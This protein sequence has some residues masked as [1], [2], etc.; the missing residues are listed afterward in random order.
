MSRF[1]NIELARLFDNQINS[2]SSVAYIFSEKAN[3]EVLVLDFKHINFLS[4]AA[5]HELVTW[6]DQC[7]AEGKSVQLKNLS[8]HLEELI[9]SVGNHRQNKSKHATYVERKHFKNN[10]ELE[11][12]LLTI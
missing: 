6:M 9:A 3:K 8:P 1:E 4:R 11:M 5:A 7:N 10:N 2:R 12:Y